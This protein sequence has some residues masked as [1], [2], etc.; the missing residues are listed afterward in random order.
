MGVWVGMHVRNGECVNPRLI[1]VSG[2]NQRN[3]REPVGRKATH[4]GN[5]DQHSQI[6]VSLLHRLA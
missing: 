6:G 5:A 3:E 1:E 4:T 2:E